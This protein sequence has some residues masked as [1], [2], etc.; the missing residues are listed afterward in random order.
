MPRLIACLFLVSSV[1]ANPAPSHA[2]GLIDRLPEDGSW[3]RYHMTMTG[4]LPVEMDAAG[5]LTIKSVGEA[6]EG[7]RKCRWL[8]IEFEA[9]M[10]GRKEHV[11]FKLLVPEANFEKKKGKEPKPAD[12]TG[13][14]VRAWFRESGGEIK[15]VTPDDPQAHGLSIFLGGPLKNRA[16]LDEPRTVQYQKGQLT[17]KA[18][19]TGDLQIRH[20]GAPVG[21][22]QEI[23]ATCWP[24][25]KVPS[26]TAA[27]RIEAV[28]KRDG[29]EQA[30]FEIEFILE[31]FGTGAK[32]ELPDHN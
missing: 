6:S 13:E 3:V 16:K 1:A 22:T 5:T 12:P 27:S 15:E 14:F 7:E 23:K 28:M 11:V 4:S 31:D 19:Y 9:E 8:E 24:H 30:R 29:M 20:V 21:F 2:D 18:A 10:M 17:C 26:G 32:S 25:E